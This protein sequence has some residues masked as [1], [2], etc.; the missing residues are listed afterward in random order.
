[1]HPGFGVYI[2]I[3]FC[4]KK[5]DY[6]AFATFTDRHQLTTDYLT[7]LRTHIKRSV[8]SSMP[9]A[10]SVFIGGG[11]P[12]LV[13]AAELMSVLAEIS[14][15]AGC[16]VT[17]ECNPDD[18]TLEM[19][20]TYR[21]GGVNRI[22]IG[23]QSTVDHVLKSLGRTH[24]PENVQRSVSFVREAGFETFNLD[25]IYGAA[26]ETLDDWSRTLRDVVALDPPH[27]SAY[28]LTVEANTVLATQLDR[29]P[30][31]DDQADKYLL[32]DDALSANGL[33]NY[34]I[35]NWA[36]PGHECKHNSLYWQQGNYEGFGSA[37]HAHLNGR[38]WWNVRTPDRYIELVNAGESPESS[39]ETLDAETS[40][41]EM[42]QLL[43][44]TREGVPHGSFSDKD[45]DEMSE[46]LDRQEDRIVLT[47]AG[48]LLANEVALRLIDAI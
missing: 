5:C 36:K 47:R 31:D 46:L 32:C 30:D 20:Q 22:S 7:A 21:A 35:S 10:T 41:R 12:T 6:C 37:A 48:R 8:A 33:Q 42:L 3:P 39:S 43:V 29:H 1:M 40:K 25:I 4:A 26:G 14:L 17:V 2:H 27:V 24:N 23:V 44:R 34:E 15:A 16:E 45:L 13:P 9:R 19:M 11:T 28:G 18:I 38:R